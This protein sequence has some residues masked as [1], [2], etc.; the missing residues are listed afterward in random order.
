M[1]DILDTHKITTDA[2]VYTVKFILDEDQHQP[3]DEGFVFMMHGYPDYVDIS[4]GDVDPIVEVALYNHGKGS[5]D[6][7]DWAYRSGAAIVRYL[8]LKGYCGVTLVDRDYRP[9]E[10][11][12]DRNTRV[13]GVAWAPEDV[14]AAMAHTY[15]KHRLQEW[16]AWAIG[17][18]F[19]YEIKDPNDVVID[20]DGHYTFYGFIDLRNELMETEIKPTIYADAA[21]RINSAN[22]IGAGFVGLI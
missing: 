18:C 17:D 21:D 12:S 20:E 2:G 16:A 7:W 5:G 13:Y 14:P 19:Y 15:V 6:A 11:T 22:R 4:E 9:V 8:R 10:A 3:E 1:N